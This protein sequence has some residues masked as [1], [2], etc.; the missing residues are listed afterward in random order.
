MAGSP[1]ATSGVEPSDRTS[2]FNPDCSNCSCRSGE[3]RAS[4]DIQS[5]QER[6]TTQQ[7]AHEQSDGMPAS[8]RG[9]SARTVR[10]LAAAALGE[11]PS[12]GALSVSAARLKP[13]LASRAS[14]DSVVLDF[15]TES[16]VF[17]P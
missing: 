5:W 3:C 13:L 17:Y 7:I 11:L 9:L 4:I 12:P 16:S 8:G 2:G 14:G 6:V 1:M 15:S 10:L